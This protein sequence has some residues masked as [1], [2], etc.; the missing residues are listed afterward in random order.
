MRDVTSSWNKLL[1]DIRG[2]DV[3]ELMRQSKS[4]MILCKSS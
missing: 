4:A 3:W 1:L 2:P